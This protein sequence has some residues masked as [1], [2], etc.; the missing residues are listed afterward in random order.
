MP[1]TNDTRPSS[2]TAN[3][4]ARKRSLLQARLGRDVGPIVVAHQQLRSRAIRAGRRAR[5]RRRERPHGAARWD[6]PGGESL[7]LA[8]MPDA[9]DAAAEDAVQLAGRLA[10]NA[11]DGLPE[12]A[13]AEK[14]RAGARRGA[15]AAGQARHR[16]DRA[17]HPPRPCG[18]AAQAARVP[19]RRPPRG[20]DRRRLHRARG[21]SLAGAP[22]LRP[23]LSERG[24]RGERDD[25]PGAGAPD[26]RPRS[27]APGGAAQ[28]RVARHADGGR[29]SRSLRTTT[30]AQ[31][32]ERD[33]FAKR[34]SAGEPISMLE[35]LYPLLQGYDSVAVRPTSSWGGPTRSSTCCWAA[36]SS[37]PTASRRRRS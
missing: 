21:R 31:L 26:P 11:V 7:A 36:T 32:L 18:R 30:V 29:C 37:A 34:W 2:S 12:G 13:L 3:R 23:M 5:S 4:I 9:T 22:S 27:R 25:L 14:L 6:P 28:Q 16:P 15:A 8:R 1:N 24:D 20:A 19:G 35:L 10:A 33:D 17:R